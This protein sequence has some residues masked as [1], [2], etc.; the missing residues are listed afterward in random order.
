EIAA[1]LAAARAA[2]PARRI[3]AVFQPH[4]YTRTRDF[5]AAFGRALAGADVVWVADV[6]AAREAPIPGVT[7]E[8]VAR[9]VEAAGGAE[10]HYHAELD[11][12]PEALAAMLVPGDVCIT[13]GA[14][15]IDA[16]GREVLALLGGSAAAAGTGEE[17]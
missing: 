7:G 3:V 6:Y 11:S 16:T 17:P 4:L 8:L 2:F 12:L 1:T 10:V 15:N 5:A 14:G 9:A 13:L